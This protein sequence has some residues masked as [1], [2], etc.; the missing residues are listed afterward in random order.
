MDQETWQAAPESLAVREFKAKGK[1]MVTTLM[2][3]K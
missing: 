1:V 3:P 2:C